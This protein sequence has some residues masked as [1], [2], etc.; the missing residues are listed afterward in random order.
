MCE[1]KQV[2]TPAGR[3]YPIGVVLAAVAGIVAFAFVLDPLIN[4]FAEPMQMA[5][6]P[7]EVTASPVFDAVGVPAW[8]AAALVVA[9]VWGSQGAA[10]RGGVAAMGGRGERTR[11]HL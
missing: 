8:I 4:A 11:R 10:T 1:I 5:L 6:P 9:V 2:N 3:G 7:P